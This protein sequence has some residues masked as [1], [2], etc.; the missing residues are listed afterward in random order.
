MTIVRTGVLFSLL[1]L[2]STAFAPRWGCV[3][4]EYTGSNES[5]YYYPPHEE[6]NSPYFTR[7]AFYSYYNDYYRNAPSRHTP[8]KVSTP[9]KRSPLPER[10][11][12]GV[13]HTESKQSDET[14]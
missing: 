12:E 9:T 1:A 6:Y 10:S 5:S 11:K 14:N 7:A 3:P 8:C 13:T 4:W 2:S